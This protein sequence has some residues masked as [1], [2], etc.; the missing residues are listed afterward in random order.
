[1]AVR[2]AVVNAAQQVVRTSMLPTA[3]GFSASAQEVADDLAAGT[4]GAGLE[5]HVWMD[6]AAGVAGPPDAVAK[7]GGAR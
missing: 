2:F 4:F 1:M 6:P 3:P 7:A 5:V